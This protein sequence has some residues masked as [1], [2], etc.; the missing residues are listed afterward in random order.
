MDN[1]QLARRP[2]SGLYDPSFEHDA[3]GVGFLAHLRGQGLARRR[4]SRPEGARA[5]G[6]SRRHRRRAQHRRRRRHPHPDS[7]RAV[8]ARVRARPHPRRPRTAS[9]SR[10]CRR[11]ASTPS[12]WS[13]RSP[14]PQAAALAKLIFAM[15][16]RQEGQP[17]LG[18]RRV[19]DRQPQPRPD[20]ALGRAG[21]GSRVPGPGRRTWP[22]RPR[23]SASCT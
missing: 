9:R 18:W 12:A 19:P 20:G 4:R 7:A 15:V 21:D 2:Q 22:T 23:S 5:H 17:L 13:S 11:P 14:D 10:R 1:T 8:R 6:A 3:C 16:V